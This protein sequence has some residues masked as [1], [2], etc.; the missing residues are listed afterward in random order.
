MQQE[1]SHRSGKQRRIEGASRPQKTLRK[2][3]K[4]QGGQGQGERW[5]PQ[6][7][8]RGQKDE[9]WACAE[10]EQ[11]R[12]R[13]QGRMHGGR[14]ESRRSTAA[15][16]G[17][18]RVHPRGAPLRDIRLRFAGGLLPPC[19]RIAHNTSAKEEKDNLH[20]RRH[21]PVT[22]TPTGAESDQRGWGMGQ[23]RSGHREVLRHPV[24]HR[25]FPLA[26]RS[27]QL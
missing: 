10:R 13:A 24:R 21:P 11:R 7:K 8:R 23:S 27:A 17:Q 16:T 1:R 5:R 22:T 6:S 26:H 4:N 15:T 9:T 25:D 18:E 19:R 20:R 14:L 3:W 2:G 12:P